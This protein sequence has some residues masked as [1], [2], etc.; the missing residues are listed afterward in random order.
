[1]RDASGKLALRAERSLRDRR[2]TPTFEALESR[3]L[4]SAV[5]SAA[6]AAAPLTPAAPAVRS[7]DGTGNNVAHPAWGSDGQTLLRLAPA[8]YADGVSAPAGASRPSA[9][10]VSNAVAAHGADALPSG[11][12]LSAYAYLWGQFIDHD[13]DLTSTGAAAEELD[14]AVPKGDPYFDP[15][16]TGTQVISLQRS[17]YA[18]GTGVTTAA[19]V[20]IPRQ[21]TTDISAFLDGSMIYGSDAARATA[22][23]TLIGGNMKTSAGDLLPWNTMGLDNATLGGPAATYFAAGDVRANENIELTSLQ[24]LFL[25]EHNRLAGQIAAKSPGM[26]DEQVYQAARRLVIAEVQKITYDEFLPALLGQGAIK[27]YSGYKP[28]VNPGISTEFSTAAYR[29]GHSMLPDDVEFLDNSGNAVRDELPL[30]QAF[31]NPAVVSSTGVDPILKYLASSNSEEIDTKVVDGLRNF[32][33]G[34]PGAGGFDLASLNIQRGRDHG[35]SDYNSTRAALGLPRVTSFAQITSDASLQSALK[36]LYGSVD[37]VDL[38]VGG[39]AE[40]HLPG[41]NVGP[42]FQRILVDQFTRARDGDRFWYQN[43]LSSDEMKLVQAT[44]LSDVVKRNSGVTTVQANAFVFD[45]QVVGRVVDDRNGNGAD[46]GDPGL[47]GRP[48]G[49]AVDGGGGVGRLRRDRRG[50]PIPLLRAGSQAVRVE[51]RGAG[52]LEI[53]RHRR[54]LDHGDDGRDDGGKHCPAAGATATAFAAADQTG[55]APAARKGAAAS[56]EAAGP[57]GGCCQPVVLI[58]RRVGGKEVR[59]DI[60]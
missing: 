41:S 47:A 16:G 15:A 13:L 50:R 28:N 48:A 46:P 43:N 53:R 23:R 58:A 40:T 38:W 29:L 55:A 6:A 60:A 57:A 37:N 11:T 1:M 4:M 5:T 35:L 59:N 9:R 30:A 25:R 20:T 26:T 49:D 22:L 33:F 10:A 45:V 27:A 36:T 8:A 18:S 24:T 2:T 39:L 32:L 17:A 42:T 7:Y 14:V 56:G 54:G 31:F 3:Q 21:Q 52:G 34:P 12:H 51:G 19:G 44:K